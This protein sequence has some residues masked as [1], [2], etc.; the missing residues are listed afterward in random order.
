MGPLGGLPVAACGCL[1]L[2]A[3][4]CRSL[5]LLA[6]GCSAGCLWLLAG[7]VLPADAGQAGPAEVPGLIDEGWALVDGCLVVPETPGS[8]FDVDPKIFEQAL[9][10]GEA[11][12][13]TADV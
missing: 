12:R 9:I 13:V 7:A 1:W 4:V 2:S 3:A 10:T 5:W 8:G 11:W 6:V